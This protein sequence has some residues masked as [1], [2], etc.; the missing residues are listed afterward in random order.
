MSVDI[1][2]PAHN[3]VEW[4]RECLLA[5]LHQSYPNLRLIIIDDG[6]TTLL[7]KEPALAAI[8]N[9]ERVIMF[10][11]ENAGGPAAARNVGLD[12]AK[13][14]Y[15]LMLDS[16]DILEPTA[17]ATLVRALDRSRA[18]FAGGAWANFS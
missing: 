14:D 12:A 18:E 9:D 15:A 10:R 17:I 8:I 16:D 7:S 11:K 1:I 5:V 2:V 13:G 3:R 6:S 4:L